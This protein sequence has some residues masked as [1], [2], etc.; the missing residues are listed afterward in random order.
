MTKPGR[1]QGR[2]PTAGKLLFCALACVQSTACGLNDGNSS[3]S[4]TEE[5]D[6]ALVPVPQAPPEQGPK[7]GAIANAVPILERPTSRSKAIG[8]LHAGAFVPRSKAPIRKTPDCDAG[9]HAI[10][11][12]GVVCLNQGATLDLAHPTLA[13]MAI[14]PALD[15]S[16]PYT[17]GRTRVATALLERD[18]AQEDAV[19]QVR[20]LP[21]GTGLAVVGS[22]SAR[23]GAGAPER[24]GLLTNGRFV[25]AQ[26]LEAAEGSS[27][28]G[29]EL[30]EK[31][32]LPVA[33]AVKRGVRYY[34]PDGE[35]FRK[36]EEIEHHV[37]L[38]LTGRYRTYY[39]QRYWA[40]PDEN[41]WVRDR[42]VTVV[43][44]RIKLPEFAQDGQR[45]IDVSVLLSTVVLY[46]GRN[47]IFAT[48]ASP[49]RDRLAI[50]GLDTPQAVT[51]LGTF[52]VVSK[53]ITHVHA[54]P[55]R[56]SERYPIFDLPWVL[57]LSSGQ[58]IHGAYWHNRFGAEHGPGDVML[59]PSDAQRVFQ[60]ATP[61]L[62]KGWHSSAADA[63]KT[64][65]FIHK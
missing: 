47:P 26:D 6:A 36:D 45:W 35:A 9:Y 2:V 5:E 54:A 21:K 14:Q 7:L 38:N 58:L 22:W 32:T 37:K 55:E 42:D 30:D 53:H 48:L 64:L 52:E 3:L 1:T 23:V 40:T 28:A 50:E 11:P 57:E 19:R 39:D 46:E 44:K 18:P 56:P 51:Q 15:K 4:K 29:F 31:T 60:W 61:A 25:R 59:S 27:F 34:K 62:P 13:A 65:V 17:Y 24:L 33:F 10:F 16:L 12:R 20:N 8:Y 63:R 41:R 49:G 43:H